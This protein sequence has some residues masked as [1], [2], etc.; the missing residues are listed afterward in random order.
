M[1]FRLVYEWY[2]K[3]DEI[4]PKMLTAASRVKWEPEYIGKRMND[5]FVNMGDWN[6]SRKRFYG[7]P[8]PFYPCLKCGHLTVIGSKSELEEFGD[9]HVKFLPELHRPWIDE[10]KIKCPKCGATVSRI[11]EVGD[12]WLD[13]GITPFSTLGY[14]TDR[15]KWETS[16]PAEWVTEMREQVRLWFYSLLF[17]SV[18]LTGKAPYERVFAYS[19]VIAEDGVKFSKTG[20]M[21]KFDEATEKIGSDAIRYLYAGANVESDVRFGFNLGDEARRKLLGFWNIYSFFMTYAAIDNP[22]IDEYK[23]ENLMDKW[24]Y[25]RISYFVSKAVKSYDNYNTPE[26]VREFEVCIDDVSN[27]Y[28]R[29]CRKRFWKESLDNDKQNA[30][31]ALY[32]AV[33]T[34]S[35]VMAPVIPFM[36]ENI[37]QNMILEFGKAA[38]SVHLSD[39]PKVQKVD[40]VILTEVKTIREI[41]AAVMKLRNE[42]QLKVKQP[43]SALYVDAAFE[44]VCN[45]Y[46]EAVKDELNVKTILFVDDFNSLCDPYLTLNFKIAGRE[47]KGDLNKVKEL[48]EALATV[49]NNIVAAK[50]NN[51][52]VTSFH[53][54]LTSDLR[55]HKYFL[56]N[57]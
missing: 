44:A 10:I 3:T 7:L 15:E 35:Q 30:Y 32:Y 12:V 11:P 13:A 1:L 46:T 45:K 6:I 31:S 21:I 16:F 47:L 48:V 28:V 55:V 4:K 43:L 37:W 5:W 57:I 14:F 38:Q 54:E 34:L 52:L 8:L 19:S 2:I 36:T 23:S 29:L 26:F 22:I 27:W 51:M 56:D 42:K 18:T 9:N 20:F 41:I 24:L 40:E 17:M 33:K 50:Q 25:N 53:P 49:D 39:F